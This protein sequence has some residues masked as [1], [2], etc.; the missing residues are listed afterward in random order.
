MQCHIEM[1]SE[2][3]DTWCET[4]AREIEESVGVSP[5]VQTPADMRE[6]LPARIEALHRVADR[7]YDRWVEGL[8]L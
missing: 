1:T 2:M 4:G 3:I 8:K 6:N 7:V 5:A